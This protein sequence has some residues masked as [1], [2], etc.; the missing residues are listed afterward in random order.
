MKDFFSTLGKALIESE[1][2]GR[3]ITTFKLRKPIL[4]KNWK[5]DLL[6]LP[7]P[8]PGKVVK[9]GLEHIEVVA[10]TPFDRLEEKFSSAV[11]DRSGLN[12]DFNQELEVILDGCAVKFHHL[13]LESV[14]NLEANRQVF[15]SL[16]TLALLKNLRQ[17]EPLIA[18]TFP[19]KIE[20]DHSDVDI[21]L[22]SQDLNLL[23]SRFDEFSSLKDFEKHRGVKEGMDYVLARFKFME[24][25]FELFGQSVRSIDQTAYR[26]FQIEERL[27]KLGG[28]LFQQKVQSLK[29]N[30]EKTEP[31][32]A[33]VLQLK[34][35][36]YQ[37]LLKIHDFS[38]EQLCKLMQDT[39]D[40]Q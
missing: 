13:S 14:V 37:A 8:K 12:K 24:I 35:D 28:A 2:N 9:E 21:I 1:V 29:K 22:Y 30:G 5:I 3:L 17:F 20:T 6:E 40:Q 39:D 18:G 27:L 10:D 34:D 4:W 23:F 7:A 15:L 19:L 36:P 31:A 11:L 25:P 32:F 26:H 33:K 16:Q 38:E